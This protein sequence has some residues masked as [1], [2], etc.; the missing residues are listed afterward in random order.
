MINLFF[1]VSFWVKDL[2][3]SI[4]LD[5]ITMFVKEFLELDELRLDSPPQ[6]AEPGRELGPQ[7]LK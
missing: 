4:S 2:I 7:E 1:V 6:G 5:S 3:N